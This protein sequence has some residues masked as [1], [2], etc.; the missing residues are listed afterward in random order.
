MLPVNKSDTA[1]NAVVTLVVVETRVSADLPCR[2]KTPV[3]LWFLPGTPRVQKS[4]RPW[5]IICNYVEASSERML[6]D[7]L[8]FLN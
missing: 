4:I 3:Y 8:L 2:R 7:F 1:C 5:R 6:F